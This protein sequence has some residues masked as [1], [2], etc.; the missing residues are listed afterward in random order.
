MRGKTVG[1]TNRFG[2][3]VSRERMFDECRRK[4][5]FH[6]YLSWGGWKRGAPLVS[7]E[8]FKLKRLVPLALWRGQLVHYVISKVLQ[9][10]RAKGRIPEI[11]AV[12]D[13]TVERFEAQLDFSR[14]KKYLITPKRSGKKLNI[15]WI[16]LFEHEYGK[17]YLPERL[18][19]AKLECITSIESLFASPLLADIAETDPGGWFIEDLDHAEFSQ[20]FE[21]DGVTVYAKTDFMFRG[22]DGCFNIVDWKTNRPRGDEG[23][24]ANEDN[25]VQLGVYGY[26]ASAILSEP[27]ER[28]RLLEVN[29]LEGG[30][31]KEHPIDDQSLALF[32][33]HIESGI[34]KFSKVLVDADVARNEPLSPNHFP[35][36][37]NGRC[38]FC[39]FYRICRDESSP[40][41][42]D[43]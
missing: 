37:E 13:Y 29:L 42:F 31:V 17:S 8:A 43:A 4:Y 12:I 35:R 2:W 18:E 16:A 9:S 1:F 39:N 36:I 28:L 40:L 5:Y 32:R 20:S 10:M 15:D 38:A 25:R 27:L 11:R 30:L 22:T 21:I 33:E 24:P 19:K 41:L 3:S 6:Y 26:Y 7:R 14:Q 23:V 34:A